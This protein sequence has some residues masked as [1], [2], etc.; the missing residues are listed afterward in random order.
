MQE[1]SV[2]IP[3]RNAGRT[4]ERCLAAVY[5]SRRPPPEVIVVDDGSVDQTRAIAGRFP[6]RLVTCHIARGPMQPRFEGARVAQHPILI[7]VDADVCVADDTFEKTL[8][9]FESGGV[10]AVTG[11]L[12]REH[13]GAAFF[14][15]FKNEYMNYI[16]TRQGRDARFLY[17][18]Y[19]A[20]RR[21][22]LIP[23]EPISEPFG[24]LVSDAELGV[25]LRADGKTIILGH[26]L[27]VL[28]LKDYSVWGLLANDFKIPFMFAQLF[29]RYG[30]ASP[31]FRGGGFAHISLAQVGS[32]LAAAGLAVVTL[33]SSW[34]P[35]NAVLAG[36]AACLLLFYGFWLPFLVRLT[37]N[38]AGFVLAAVLFLPLDACCMF[39]GMTAGFG[40]AL[41]R[42]C[43][44]G[45]RT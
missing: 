42:G 41:R 36:M 31:W 20:I 35:R 19:W 1:F 3:A 30:H 10:H 7:F 2:I 29:S 23:F 11:L 17:G 14:G 27:E 34:L 13:P 16:F 8:R 6:C 43:R 44:R 15:R 40:H 32:V 25:R 26:D 5:R 24:S 12:A 4:L 18:S 9:Y 22:A 21:E 28:H 38:G 39:A 45:R 33:A 37:R